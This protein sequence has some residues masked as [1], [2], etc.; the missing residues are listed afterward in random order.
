MAAIP[1]N[2]K[3]LFWDDAP[4]KKPVDV[5]KSLRALEAHRDAEKFALEKEKVKATRATGASFFNPAKPEDIVL[6]VA[7]SSDTTV[8]LHYL[9]EPWL[10]IRQVIG[11]YGRGGTAK[12]SFVATHAAKIAQH[13]STLWI[14][15]E[16][17]TSWIKVRHVKAGGGDGTLYV[18]K[19]LV[20]KHDLAGRPASFS[21][22]IY[23]H[24]DA[25][26]AN[27]KA[28]TAANAQR[29]YDQTERPLRLVVLD[30]AVA[31]TT[32]GKGES[33]N[34]DASVK[35]LIAYLYSLCDK[36]D[37]TIALIGHVNKGKHEHI[38]DMVAGSGSWTSSLRQAFMHIYDKRA[39]Y[40][41][42]VCTVKDTLTGAFAASYGTYPVHTLV[43]RAEGSDSVLCATQTRPIVWGYK[44]VKELIEDATDQDGGTNGTRKLPLNRKREQVNAIVATL[45]QMLDSGTE[46]VT[47]K[48]VQEA[49]GT[50]M[51]FRHWQE[52]DSV[53]E[54]DHSVK[55]M[56]RGHAELVYERQ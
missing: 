50:P 47:R 5:D 56:P 44:Y 40:N 23:E 10:P 30:T 43:D 17:D 21:F 25:A 38:A 8:Q 14:S 51:N 7:M 15:T 9:V 32:W 29:F 16:E 2:D 48:I 41:Y 39:E 55:A 52:A 54:T 19:A 45:L 53:L 24:L 27:A 28:Q 12:S 49:L 35:R 1:Q 42:V 3:P 36:H 33:P 34:D 37:V 13:S 22:N 26:I 31:L 4:A 6:E 11:F 46:P 20:T 18:F